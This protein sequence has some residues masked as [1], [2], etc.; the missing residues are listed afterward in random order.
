MQTRTVKSIQ[1][2]YPNPANINA[3][4]LHTLLKDFFRSNDVGDLSEHL[5]DTLASYIQ[6]VSGFGDEYVEG[7]NPMRQA[8]DMN[9]ALVTFLVKLQI[10][11]A[12]QQL[13]EKEVCND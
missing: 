1:V 11:H 6:E 7:C 8:A 9:G 4:K 10:L 5:S 3:E 12:E 13:N 2:F